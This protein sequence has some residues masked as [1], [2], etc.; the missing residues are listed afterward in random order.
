MET[1]KYNMLLKFFVRLLIT[2]N[3]MKNYQLLNN[4]DYYVS[5]EFVNLS[6]Y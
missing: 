3:I 4:F 5:S 1:D 2:K 6:I